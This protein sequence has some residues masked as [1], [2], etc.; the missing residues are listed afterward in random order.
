[1]I[2]LLHL[3][4]RGEPMRV[5]VTGGTGFVG[6]HVVSALLREGHGVVLLVHDRKKEGRQGVEQIQGNILDAAVLPRCMEGCDA[7]INLVG[8]IREFPG[9]GVTFE[10]LHV[11]ATRNAV[12]AARAA[13]VVRYIQMSALGTRPNAVS[14]YHTSKFRAEEAVRGSRLDWTIFRPSIIFGPRD[15]F[16]NMIAGQIRRF[17]LV[18]VIGNGNYR[19]QPISAEDVA[20]CFT[21]A[22]E[23]PETKAKTYEIC[24]R[25]RLSYNEVVDAVGRAL[26]RDS[27]F[28]AKAPLSVMEL[29]VPLLQNIPLFPLTTDQMLMLLEENICDGRWRETFGFDPVPFEAGIREYLS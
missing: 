23:M 5:F 29:I 14:R 18:P 9:R 6:G 12:A 7:A 26:G 10:E 2:L 20:R 16:V 15:A 11:E 28:K 3:G 22:L 1:M 25:D 13:G 4:E 8:I 17:G 19:L 27:V 21:T 24:G